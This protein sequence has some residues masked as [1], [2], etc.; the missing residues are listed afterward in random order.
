MHLF[1]GKKEISKTKN[2]PNSRLS[3]SEIPLLLKRGSNP[4]GRT[5]YFKGLQ[6]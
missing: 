2:C 4:A 6:F 1:D 5:N 3:V